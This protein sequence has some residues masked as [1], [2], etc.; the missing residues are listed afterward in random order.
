MEELLRLDKE[1]III[2]SNDYFDGQERL[3]P[4]ENQLYCNFYDEIV[5]NWTID[6]RFKESPRKQGYYSLGKMKFLV[7]HGPYEILNTGFK[8]N[9]FNGPHLLGTCEIVE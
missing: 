5:G 1:V 2:W 9:F 3:L 8:F 4:D 7:E 6:F